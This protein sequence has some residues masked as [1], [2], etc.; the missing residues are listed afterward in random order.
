MSAAGLDVISNAGTC[1]PSSSEFLLLICRQSALIEQT[2]TPEEGN[3][4]SRAIPEDRPKTQRS[5]R[6][7]RSPRRPTRLPMVTKANPRERRQ[8]PSRTSKDPMGGTSTPPPNGRG[9]CKN[10]YLVVMQLQ[11]DN[12]QVNV[13]T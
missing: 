9:T 5:Q 1:K 2:S 13:G 12:T 3:R 11:F 7:Q 4:E 8:R 6:S 10:I